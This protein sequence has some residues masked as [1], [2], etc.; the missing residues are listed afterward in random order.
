MKSKCRAKKKVSFKQTHRITLRSITSLK[1]TSPLLTASFCFAHS[2]RFCSQ[3]FCSPLF[4]SNILLITFFFYCSYLQ[5]LIHR[6]ILLKFCC[7]PYRLSLFVHFFTFCSK[8]QTKLF[9]QNKGVSKIGKIKANERKMK[10]KIRS[11]KKIF[12]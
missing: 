9:Q 7:I 4:Y 3:T 1:V 11:T 6:S 10:V 12:G 8:R 2:F 5:I